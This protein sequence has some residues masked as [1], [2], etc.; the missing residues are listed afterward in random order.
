MSWAMKSFKCGCGASL[1]YENVSCLN[2]QRDAGWCPVCA[3]LR[4]VDQTNG[5]TTCE[6]CKT[7]LTACTNRSEFNVCN[8]YVPTAE[9]SPTIKPLCGAC[10]FNRVIPDLSITGYQELWAKLEAAKRRLLYDLD[11]VKLPYGTAHEGYQ[12]G[13]LF[14]FTTDHLL[15]NGKWEKDV[16]ATAPVYTGHDNGV[17][18]INIREA[19]DVEREKMRVGMHEPQRTLIG[20]FRHEISHYFWDLLVKGKQ[21]P[22]CVSIFGDHNNPTYENAQ[23]DYYANGPKA[24]WVGNYVS[25]YSTMHPWEDFAETF[26]FYLDMIGTLDTAQA[27]KLSPLAMPGADVGKGLIRY[28]ELALGLNEVNRHMGL[29]DLLPEIIGAGVVKKVQYV[30]Q[31]VTTA[32]KFVTIEKKE[33]ALQPA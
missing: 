12:P 21:E 7:E 2:C 20:H 29:P 30:H 25:A 27:Q 17:I 16:N 22:E 31:L 18:V 10:K 11:L 1:F 24:G 9:V 23:K 15:I 32:D 6:K 5:K 19:D 33:P 14:E 3:S 8:R 26:A 28:Q 4:C 13:L